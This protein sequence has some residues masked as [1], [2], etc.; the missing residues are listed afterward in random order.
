MPKIHFL[1]GAFLFSVLHYNG[2]DFLLIDNLQVDL[3]FYDRPS[4]RPDTI[5]NWQVYLNDSL[6]I[7]DNVYRD[8]S[9][10]EVIIVNFE[11][12]IS[13]DSIFIVHH[14]CSW[15]AR[16]KKIDFVNNK[17]IEILS[18]EIADEY[19]SAPFV[20]DYRQIKTLQ[21]KGKISILY[22]EYMT[23]QYDSWH[24][25]HEKSIGY[26][27]PGLVLCEIEIH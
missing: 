13:T 22:N 26:Q 23:T 1:I 17:D 9:G 14:T 27:Y 8:N 11:D 10:K 3:P 6:L 15:Y 25:R 12:I 20:L 7:A 4:F 16:M 21:G 2:P 18:I 19:G 24:D 5:E